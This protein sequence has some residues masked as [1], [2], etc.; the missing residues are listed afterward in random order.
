MSSNTLSNSD[1]NAV[2]GAVHPPIIRKATLQKDNKVKLAENKPDKFERTVSPRKVGEDTETT[3]TTVAEPKKDVLPTVLGAI[4]AVTGITA[5]AVAFFK[6]PAEATKTAEKL[7]DDVAK[8]EIK[9]L[10]GEVADLTTKLSEKAS[11]TD[12][13][14]VKAGIEGTVEK[15]A[16][17]IK[18]LREEILINESNQSL[19]SQRIEDLQGGH[20]LAIQAM[21]ERLEEIDPRIGGGKIRVSARIKALFTAPRFVTGLFAEGGIPSALERGWLAFDHEGA[22]GHLYKK[23][24]TT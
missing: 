22:W 14:G 23:A 15:L 2:N 16:E 13:D 24:L 18:K 6:K 12:L 10:Q 20:T 11:K 4:G 7:V 3:A 17:Q 19:R 5:L 8:T 1:F 21:Q 9:K